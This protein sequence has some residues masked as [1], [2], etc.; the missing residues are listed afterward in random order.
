MHQCNQCNREFTEEPLYSITDDLTYCSDECI[1][2]EATDEPYSFEYFNLVSSYR[3]FAKEKKKVENLTDREDLENEMDLV[4]EE[5]KSI[6]FGDSE[7]LYY[8]ARILSLYE[9]FLQLYEDVHNCLLENNEV[10]YAVIICWDE[11]HGSIDNELTNFIYEDILDELSNESLYYRNLTWDTTK[12]DE[13]SPSHYKDIICFKSIEDQTR[14]SN[15]VEAVF[16]KHQNGD[17][18][19]NKGFDEAVLEMFYCPTVKKCPVCGYWED[20]D[21]F[22]FDEEFNLSICNQNS[23]CR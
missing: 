17:N 11:L 22:S 21:D 14:F 10:Y 18:T 8:R 3:H 6:Y 16:V 13:I 1:P 9:K 20:V 23:A 19:L 15:I 7:G 12:E 4:I 5:Y 2:E